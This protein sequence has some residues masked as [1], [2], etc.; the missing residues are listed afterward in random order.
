MKKNK[1]NPRHIAIIM[2]GNGRWAKKRLRS[3]IFGHRQA[4]SSVRDAI[5]FCARHK[6]QE[7]TL[8]AF[9]RENWERPQDEVNSLMQMFYDYL[10]KESKDL[11]KNNIQLRVIGDKN[12]LSLELQQK[13]IQAQDFTAACNALKLNIAIDYSGQWDILELIKNINKANIDI[14]KLEIQDLPQYFGYNTLPI[15]LLIRTS[16][17]QRISNFMLWQLAYAEMFFTDTMWPDFREKDMQQALDFYYGR[18][19]R[20]GMV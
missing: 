9:G 7:L 16:G 17:E 20:F 2:D 12:R 6:I 1:S 11:K 3:R 4:V 15:D 19:R 14:N 5:S 13:I 10:D 8:F 18:D